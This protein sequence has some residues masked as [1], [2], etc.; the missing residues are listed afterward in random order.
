MTTKSRCVD[1][2]WLRDFAIQVQIFRDELNKSTP[3]YT[4]ENDEAA[5]RTILYFTE[6]GRE[7]NRLRWRGFYKNFFR[8]EL[9][10][11]LR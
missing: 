4:Q 1:R 3:M 11:R 6:P 2:I 5:S 10:Q 8:D 7:H 9:R